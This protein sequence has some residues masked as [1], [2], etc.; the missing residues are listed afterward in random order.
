MS[1]PTRCLAKTRPGS[2][3]S[4]ARV[5]AFMSTATLR[6][7]L[8]RGPLPL[9]ERRMLWRHVLEVSSAWLIAHDDTVPSPDKLA[10]YHQ[11]E[12]RR[13]KGEPMAYIL[14]QREFMGHV[15]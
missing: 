11:L 14:G 7:H 12:I 2:W 1:S 9:L 10:H 3:Q 4:L 5:E 13:I 8:S 6:E 15:F